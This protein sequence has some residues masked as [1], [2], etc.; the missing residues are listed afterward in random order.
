D[1]LI[2]GRAPDLQAQPDSAR[3]SLTVPEP[4]TPE[5]QDEAAMAALRAQIPSIPEDGEITFARPLDFGE[6]A[7]DGKSI[8]ELIKGKPAFPPI[9]G[10][11]KQIWD[12]QCT[13]CHAWTQATLCEQARTYDANDVRIMR[14]PH[15]LGAR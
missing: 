15:P 2:V 14:L 10:L 7:L 9:E 1:L 3:R 4:A 13:S 11:D 12:T 6:P 5:P 8:A